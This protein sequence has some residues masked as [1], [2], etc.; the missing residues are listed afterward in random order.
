[1]MLSF[2]KSFSYMD[3]KKKILACYWTCGI[4]NEISM[5]LSIKKFGCTLFSAI[6]VTRMTTSIKAKH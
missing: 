3:L 6:G 4:K 5:N 2:T 1:M